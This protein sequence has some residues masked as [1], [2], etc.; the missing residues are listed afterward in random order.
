MRGGARSLAIV[1]G[2]WLATAPVAGA[3]V[4]GGGGSARTDCLLA[5]DAPVN[6]PPT[7]PKKIRCTDGDSNCDADGVVNGECVFRVDVCANSTFDPRCTLSGVLSITVD[8]A[9]D[10]GDPKFDTTFQA[11]QG[12]INQLEP[13]LTAADRC[14]TTQAGGGIRV[15]LAGPFPGDVC[16][17]GVKT[18]K[19]V[20][21]S[22]FQAGKQYKDTDTLKLTCEP[23]VPCDPQVLFGDPDGGTFKRIQNQIFNQNCALSGCHDSQ[24]AQGNQI[25]EEGTAYSQIVDVT[26][27]NAVAASRGWKRIDAANMSPETSFMYHKLT[28][29][30]DDKDLGARM[31]FGRAK[32]DQFL[33]DI[34]KLWIEAGAPETGWVP[35]TD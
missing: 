9:L 3:I 17:R 7:K 18:L 5:L 14:T 29:D 11:L 4:I 28:G 10:N 25:L 32:L 20:T 16:K 27:H 2:V 6:D 31:P 34:V 24:S 15:P 33:I 12:R 1:A 23:P 21:L 22:T 13:P 8:H 19:I 30:L 35:G 26:A